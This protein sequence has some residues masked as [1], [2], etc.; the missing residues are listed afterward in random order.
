MLKIVC[1]IYTNNPEESEVS[2]V[3]WSFSH[4]QEKAVLLTD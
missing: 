3:E 2:G 4:N 1:Y